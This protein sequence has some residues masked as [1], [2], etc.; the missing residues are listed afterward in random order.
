MK[1]I[2]TFHETVV[3]TNYIFICYDEADKKTNK[4]TL[5]VVLGLACHQGTR[6]KERLAMPC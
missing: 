3:R 6:L 2:V 4:D 1:I 5:R